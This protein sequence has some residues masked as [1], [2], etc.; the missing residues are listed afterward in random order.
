[1]EN[2]IY[3]NIQH[4]IISSYRTYEEWKQLY[5]NY[6]HKSN[7][8]LTVP[9][10]NGNEVKIIHNKIPP[11]SSY[12]TYEEWKLLYFLFT[13]MVKINVL[14]VPM[15]NGNWVCQAFP[16]WRV[17]VLTVPMRNGNAKPS[18]KWR[19]SR[20]TVLTV[21]MRNGNIS[22]LSTDCVSVGSYRT[23]EEWK[24]ILLIWNWTANTRSYRTY[25][26]WKPGW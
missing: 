12:R 20:D 15:R 9:M 13:V 7:N 18:E 16:C 2:Q 19:C 1:M 8:V 3:P 22:I 4:V 10:R 17:S 14:T 11:S 21:P 6:L 26:E 23:Y 24:P 5:T 25:E